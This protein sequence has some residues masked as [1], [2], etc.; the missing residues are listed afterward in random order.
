MNNA[1]LIGLMKQFQQILL[2]N[3]EALPSELIGQIDELL[4]KL[5]DP[6]LLSAL[7]TLLGDSITTI[8]T[9]V[10]KVLEIEKKL[11][12][13]GDGEPC[14]SDRIHQILGNLQHRPLVLFGIASAI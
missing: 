13:H 4:E 3:K 14:L 5:N 2:L 8:L 11:L 1:D 9:S 10:A 7:T 12:L 6:V